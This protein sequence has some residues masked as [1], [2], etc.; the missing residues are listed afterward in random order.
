MKKINGLKASLIITDIFFVILIIFTVGLPWMVSWYAE[1][2]QRS[3]T[4]ATTILVTCYPCAPFAGALLLYLRRLL[5]NCTMGNIF[6]DANIL[7]FTKM[8]I[9]CIIISVIT[10]IAGNF[11]MPF[12]I[13]G[14]TFAFLALLLFSL[15]GIFNSTKQ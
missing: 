13:V 12:L 8:Y 10:L 2:M 5:K 11:Y 14:A 1:V 3:A 4:L 6:T 7:V 15:K 9:C